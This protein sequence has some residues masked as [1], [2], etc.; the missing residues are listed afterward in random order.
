MVDFSTYTKLHPESSDSFGVEETHDYMDQEAMERKAPLKSDMI[1]LFPTTLVAYDFHRKRWGNL[2][3]LGHRSFPLLTFMT[4]DIEV[5][6]IG[7][8]DWNKNA[9]EN[10]VIDKETKHLVQALVSTTIAT[11]KSTDL[12][13]GKGR[14]LI[15]LL[16]G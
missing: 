12:I 16:H 11:E 2:I 13:S 4:V 1:Y 8:V 5:D 14:G 10:L 6:R 15:I 9:F 3:A 7:D